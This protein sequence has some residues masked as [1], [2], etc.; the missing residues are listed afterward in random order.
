MLKKIK[1]CVLAAAVLMLSA[2]G[3]QGAVDNEI[4]IPIYD[5]TGGE[6]VSTA[7]VEYRDLSDTKTVGC[8]IGYAYAIDVRTEVQGNLVSFNVARSQELKAGDTIAVIDSSSL[9]YDY[10][11]QK[12][13]TDDAYSNYVNLGGEKNRLLY[14][15]N[16]A[17]LDSIQYEIDRYTVKAPYDCTVTSVGR[18]EVGASI[19]SGTAMCTIVKP[20]EVYVYAT[21]DTK[22]FS[23]GTHVEIKLTTNERYKGTVV[24][25]PQTIKG[26]G[27]YGR[28]SEKGV[29][30]NKAVIINLDEGERE[31]LL[32]DIPNAVSAGW[33]TIYVTAT[34][35]NHVLAVPDS[36]VKQFSG[37][38]YCN[39]LENEQKLQIPVEIGESIGG[40]TI[41]L[42]GLTE[43]DTI[44]I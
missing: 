37:E 31:R 43:G 35:K 36:A 21:S 7:V 26:N 8:E 4:Q 29:N 15:E 16:K 9:D 6:S 3:G 12:L 10:Q 11:S 13:L 39:V 32:T 24:M 42:S 27:D 38:V 23:L 5:N 28:L 1:G 41:I 40:Y 2:C 44:V 30:L 19:D 14:E 34:E 17:I 25:T 22:Y 33:A 20:E 18:F